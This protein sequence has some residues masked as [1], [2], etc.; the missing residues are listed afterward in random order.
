MKDELRVA[1][2]GCGGMG[3]SL[4][5]ALLATGEARLVVAYDAVPE[6]A[7]ELTDLCGAEAAGSAEALL[8]YSGLDGVIIALPPYLHAPAAQQA[9]EAGLGI[10]LE[11]PMALTVA[12]CQEINAAVRKARVPLMVGHVLRYYEPYRTIL[13]WQ[14]E[15]RLSRPFAAS[16]WRF[17]D[18]NRPADPTHWRASLAKSGGFIF[19]V[20][21]HELDMLRCLMGQ[22]R[23]VAAVREKALPR[24]QEW[25]DFISLQIRFAEGG[26]GIYEG[27]AGSFAPGYGFRLFFPEMTLVSQA[28]FDPRALQVYRAGGESISLEGEFSTEH[29]V[30]AELRDWLRALRG[31]AAVPITG[32]EATRTVALAEAGLRAAASGEIVR[33]EV[34]A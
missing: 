11:K 24:P 29:P 8:A 7:A 10:F 25:E 15:G 4:A 14:R 31:E 20:G 6:R 18:A 2:W 28:A 23:T 34:P 22:P 27:G 19:E 33:Y 16:I 32:E 17:S 12:A 9:A 3:R 21:A 13:R 5:Q 30:Q 1:L 26:A